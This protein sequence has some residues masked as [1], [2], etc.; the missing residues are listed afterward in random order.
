VSG[1]VLRE[2]TPEDFSGIWPIFSAI[3]RAGETYAYDPATTFEQGRL[4]WMAPTGRVFVAVRDV[5]IVGTY[6]L[7][8]NQPGLGDHVANAS[9]LVDPGAQG[10]G[11]GRALVVHCLREARNAGFLAMQFNLVVATNLAAIGLWR[12]VGFGILATVPGAFR[13]ARLGYVDTHVMFRSLLDLP[14][15]SDLDRSGASHSP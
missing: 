12:S 9:F 13:H 2:A 7:K 3:V 5:A 8:P 14:P 6:L 1:L 15:A 4:L 11:I 10:Q